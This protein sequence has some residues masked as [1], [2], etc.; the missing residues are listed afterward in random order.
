MI[1]SAPVFRL[2]RQAKRLS[3]TDGIP[4]VA[5]LDRIARQEGFQSWSLL[6]ARLSK[7]R[8]APDLLSRLQPGDL[9]LLGARPGQGKTLLG[10]D[11]IVEALK[12]GRQGV[13]ITLEYN[14]ADVLD[15]LRSIGAEPAGLDG[16]FTLDT[17]DDINAAT[18]IERL[19]DPRPGAIAVVDYLQVLDQ[20]RTSPA[21]GAQLADLKAF[22]ATS[23]MILVFLSQIDRSYALSGNPMPDIGDIRMPNPVDPAVFSKTC[24]LNDGRIRFEAVA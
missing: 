13:F 20:K 6:A 17:S 8:P 21:I 24:F 23:G 16:G 15:S 3:R 7:S 1:L 11:L 5:A 19:A 2:K 14:D 9:V 18:I 10:L 22:A 4:L 12:A